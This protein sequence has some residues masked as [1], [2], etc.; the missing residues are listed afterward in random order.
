MK[1]FFFVIFLEL[2]EYSVYDV[3]DLDRRL[4][5]F[6]LNK[7]GGKNMK[8][9]ITNKLTALILCFAAFVMVSYSIV[10][11]FVS[12]EKVKVAA[13]VEL[14]GCASIT[15]GTIP[16]D[17]LEKVISGDANAL[18]ETRAKVD[19]IVDSKQIFKS[20]LVVDE[21][22]K[23]LVADKRILEEGTKEGDKFYVDKALLKIAEHAEHTGT[24]ETYTDVY[25]FNDQKRMAGYALIPNDK[26]IK[27]YM[28]LE[29]DE[30][31]ISERTWDN[32]LPA[33][34]IG[35]IF[36]ILGAIITY[37]M[38]QRGVRPIIRMSKEVDLIAQGDLSFEP[39][40]VDSKDEIGLLSVSIQSMVKNLSDVLG[41][42]NET[43]D[44]LTKSSALLHKESQHN[45]SA[46]TA[47]N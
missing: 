42:V 43:G 29:F 33:I 37:L 31:I 9:S 6:S 14:V 16:S 38:F 34:K 7:E 39:T 35:W 10:F 22:G 13:G 8:M 46:N 28:V 36:P 17:L 3:S 24:H 19:W 41:K 18:K 5:V 2:F 25:T 21:N 20:A 45:L 12:Y 47:F 40:V 15:S 30:S 23:V 4:I 27:A 44:Q 1:A 26:G 32:V 11:Y